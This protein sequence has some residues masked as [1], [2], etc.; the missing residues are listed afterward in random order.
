MAFVRK[1]KASLVRQDSSLYVGEETYLF[2][3][4]VTGCIQMYDGTP[5]GTPICNGAG[6]TLALTD[7][8]DVDTTGVLTGDVIVFDGTGWVAG[9]GSSGSVPGLTVTDINSQPTL[10]LIDTTRSNKVLSVAENPVTFT[11]NKLKN[12]EWLRIGN[13]NHATVAYIAEFDGTI[14]YSSGHCQL[15]NDNDKLIHVYVNNVDMGSLGALTGSS[16][17]NFI[18][19]TTNIDFNQGDLIRL[20]A[21]NGNPGLIKD[22]IVKI[23]LKWRG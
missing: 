13:S 2:Y 16:V 17:G 3:D 20:R 10:T 14:T 7:L 18:N 15:V 21:K 22:T 12:N 19:T 5:G 4:I 23:I 9:S 11:N 8:T 1:I 6:S